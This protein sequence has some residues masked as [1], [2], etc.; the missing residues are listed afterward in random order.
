[1][2]KKSGGITLFIPDKDGGTSII[3]VPLD[4][5]FPLRTS[6]DWLEMLREIRDKDPRIPSINV[7]L[8]YGVYYIITTYYP[9]LSKKLQ[10]KK[11]ILLN[12]VVV[13]EEPKKELEPERYNLLRLKIRALE[14]VWDKLDP[15]KRYKEFKS[16]SEE[17]ERLR[18]KGYEIPEEFINELKTLSAEIEETEKR[19]EKKAFIPE[20]IPPEPEKKPE[21]TRDELIQEAKNWIRDM[22][23]DRE[24]YGVI[25]DNDVKR[26]RE[27]LE[28]L[29]RK[30]GV[31]K[32]LRKE[33]QE[34]TSGV[35][36]VDYRIFTL[37]R[38]MDEYEKT[39]K[40]MLRN[41]DKLGL[42]DPKRKVRNDYNAIVRDL[43]R[44]EREKG[45][46]KKDLEPLKAK[47]KKLSKLKNE[48]LKKL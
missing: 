42:I 32:D 1:M 37:S 34:T 20:P 43:N 3:E 38:Q 9:E 14:N 2:R 33:F 36:I 23:R 19:I 25:Q 10:S 6:R 46:N 21:K 28:I 18:E 5:T 39:V 24:Q 48:A 31:P 11:T 17:L 29:E 16:I 40:D 41:P 47:L 22:R 7:L 27:I 12:K 44:L 35:K 13:G 45:I 4:A 30:G 8:N 26:V 15:N